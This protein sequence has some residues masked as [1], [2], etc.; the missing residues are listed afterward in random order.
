MPVLDYHAAFSMRES[1]ETDMGGTGASITV[2][3]SVKGMRRVIDA[4]TP[5]A[6][7]SFLDWKGGTYPW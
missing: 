5:D 4:L 7:G 1:V 2:E 3:E 6:A